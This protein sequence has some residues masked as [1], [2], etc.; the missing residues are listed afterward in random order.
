M[1]VALLGPPCVMVLRRVL[2][3]LKGDLLEGK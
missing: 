3:A 1:F 2:G